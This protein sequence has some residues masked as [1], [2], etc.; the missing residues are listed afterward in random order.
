MTRKRASPYVLGMSGFISQ[1]SLVADQTTL[2]G[3][4]R[5]VPEPEREHEDE[6]L[7]EAL[8]ESFPASDPLS[9]WAGA[10]RRR[11]D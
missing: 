10:D 7:D 1:R 3:E 9:S 11:A 4:Q 6:L 8:R 2:P 5:R